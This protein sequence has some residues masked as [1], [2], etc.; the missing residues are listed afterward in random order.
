MAQLLSEF[1]P[2]L[3]PAPGSHPPPGVFPTSGPL[4]HG[5]PKAARRLEGRP[6]ARAVLLCSHADA[7]GLFIP[8]PESVRCG[9]PGSPGRVSLAHAGEP[10][11]ARDAPPGAVLLSGAVLL[12]VRCSFPDS[13]PFWIVLLPARCSSRRRGGGTL[14][15]R[16]A[17]T[18]GTSSAG[19]PPAPAPASPTSPEPELFPAS[20]CPQLRL[21]APGF[22]FSQTCTIRL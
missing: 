20:R 12:P 11:R 22:S 10:L 21:P 8:P 15:V 16:S 19:Q 4:C 17:S 14:L 18:G 9:D 5:I 2:G 7:D 1:T 6:W 3:P 13:A